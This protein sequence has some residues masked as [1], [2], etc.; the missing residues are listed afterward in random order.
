MEVFLNVHTRSVKG[1]PILDE[2]GFWV[3][4]IKSALIL[5]YNY[6]PADPFPIEY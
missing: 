3:L 1:L 4:N 2:V 5:E 6:Y